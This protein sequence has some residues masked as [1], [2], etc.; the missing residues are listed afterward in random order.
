MGWICAIPI[1]LSA[2]ELFLTKV[3]GIPQTM[4]AGD[5]NLYTL[6]EIDGHN[7]VIASMPYGEY[8][9]A[10]VSMLQSFP[11][12]RLCLLVG[13]ASGAPAQGDINV[14][15]GDIVVGFGQG[16]QHGGVIQIRL[17]ERYARRGL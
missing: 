16:I 7:I 1:E 17:W 15:L 11:N 2:A 12:V 13:V 10:A 8:G 6:R 14:H 5:S 9:T 3:H 4:T